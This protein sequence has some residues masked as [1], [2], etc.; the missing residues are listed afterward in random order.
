[1]RL[2]KSCYS[3]VGFTFVELVIVIVLLSIFAATALPRFINITDNAQQATTAF[4]AANFSLGINL[5]YTAYQVRQQ[6]PITFGNT[7]VL[8]DSIS[9]WPTG[10]GSGVQ[11]CVN[12][13]NSVVD[14]S[15]NITGKINTTVPL[16]E[17]WNS[18]GNA[19]FCAYSKKTGDLTLAG[20]GLPHFIYYIRDFGPVTSGG[21]TY[22]G[23]AGEIQLYN[24]Q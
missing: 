8:I 7:T 3:Q 24:I 2:R 4:E 22:Q 11:F 18:F 17:G 19:F 5:V 9:N 6:S 16:S 20:G 1:L 23:L 12:L 14:T 15:V 13:W 10:S 21:Q